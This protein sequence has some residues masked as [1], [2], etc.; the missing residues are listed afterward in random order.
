MRQSYVDNFPTELLAPQQS[1]DTWLN[2][3]RHF[4]TDPAAIA[5]GEVPG[6]WREAIAQ[7]LI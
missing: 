2:S 4:V 7:G 5:R 3:F 6:C 1:L